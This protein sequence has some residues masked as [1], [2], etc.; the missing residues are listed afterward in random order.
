MKYFKIANR[1]TRTT[2]KIWELTQEDW[3]VEMGDYAANADDFYA[4]TEGGETDYE[5]MDAHMNE[6]IEQAEEE[7]RSEYGFDNGDY[8][9][10]IKGDDICA[11][12][13]ADGS[14]EFYDENEGGIDYKIDV[15]RALESAGYNSARIRA[16]K[17]FPEGTVQKFRR[18]DTS[19]SLDT[20]G[21]LCRLLDMQP[22]DLIEYS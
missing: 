17:I 18:L 14:V 12:V 4:E 10:Y 3:N 11:T 2:Q 22:A 15:I 16:E 8:T 13:K 19:I 9:L 20:L 1:G 21:K 5:A 6:L 7:A